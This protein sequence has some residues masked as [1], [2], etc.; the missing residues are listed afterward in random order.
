MSGVNLQSLSTRERLILLLAAVVAF[1]FVFTRGVPIVT[2]VYAERTAS[3]ESVQLDIERELRLQRSA[4]LWSSRRTET[5]RAL[6]NAEA[7]L[8]SGSTNAIV[9]ASIQQILSQHAASAGIEVNSTRLAETLEQGEW[10][11]VSQEMSFRTS[12]AAATVDFLSLIEQS[13]PRLEVTEFSLDR[14]RNQFSGAITVVG[15]ARSARADLQ[16]SARSN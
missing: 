8:F 16:L 13:I 9:E 2:R 3:V 5:E 4:E 15:F 10:T 1:V 7:G 11:L 6:A 12:D 14:S